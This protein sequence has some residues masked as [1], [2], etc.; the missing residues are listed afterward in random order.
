MQLSSELPSNPIPP[1]ESLRQPQ[2]DFSIPNLELDAHS[3]P[4]S[5]IRIDLEKETMADLEK[6]LMA[7]YHLT[8]D[9]IRV[10]RAAYE[11]RR[12]ELFLAS[13]K[14]LQ[15]FINKDYRTANEE[16]LGGEK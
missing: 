15:D 14:E 9:E 16:T 12:K 2:G 11:A 8:R 13:R 4:L 6:R 1:K 5:D 10:I 3:A 7:D